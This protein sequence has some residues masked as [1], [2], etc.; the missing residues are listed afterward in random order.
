MTLVASNFQRF[1]RIFLLVAICYSAADLTAARIERQLHVPAAVTNTTTTNVTTTTGGPPPQLANVGDLQNVLSTTTPPA[2]PPGSANATVPGGVGPAGPGAPGT[3]FVQAAPTGPPPRLT[4]TLAGGGHSLAV[5]L[6]GNETRV[7]GVGESV[8]GYTVTDVGQFSVTVRDGAGNVQTLTMDLAN[9]TGNS[10]AV[11]VPPP[12]QTA[13]PIVGNTTAGNATAP[14]PGTLSSKV[15]KDMLNNAQSFADKIQVKGIRKG[16]EVV[17]M[18][19]NYTNQDNPFAKL[20]IQAGDVITSFN[21]HP[22]KGPEDLTWAY[23]EL[24]NA[25]QLNFQIERGGAPMPL[26]IQLTE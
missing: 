14:A 21:G 25:Q 23:G 20:G 13:S 17:G 12:V 24:R 11:P 5:L 16:D 19:V 6:V 10:T 3:G 8:N 15:L 7:V 4:G 18:Q 22:L 9:M 2:P 1:A 26:T